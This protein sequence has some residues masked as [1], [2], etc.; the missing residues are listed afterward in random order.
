[1]LVA[2]SSAP[3]VTVEVAV[4]GAGVEVTE[5]DDAAVAAAAAIG[6]RLIGLVGSVA[7]GMCLVAEFCDSALP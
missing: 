3:E 6:H 1:V 5:A 2:I 7:T 4:E